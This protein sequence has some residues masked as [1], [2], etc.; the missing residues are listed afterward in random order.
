[1]D[2]HSSLPADR[3]SARRVQSCVFINGYWC[4]SIT[5]VTLSETHLCVESTFQAGILLMLSWAHILAVFRA[6][7]H[8]LANTSL[9]A[10]PGSRLCWDNSTSY[11]MWIWVT[12]FKSIPMQQYFLKIPLESLH[13]CPGNN[14][15]KCGWEYYCSN[16]YPNIFLIIIGNKIPPSNLFFFP[17]LNCLLLSPFSES[18][19]VFSY[20]YHAKKKSPNISTHLLPNIIPCWIFCRDN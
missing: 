5:S 2:P 11:I 3:G 4:F 17:S 16:I 9:S 8:C 6:A 14:I 7:L 12:Y 13:S 15:P 19:I 1:M 18:P 20:K 10:T